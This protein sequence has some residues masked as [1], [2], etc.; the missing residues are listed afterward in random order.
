MTT[1]GI[2]ELRDTLTRTIR[3]V[4]AGDRVEITRDGNAFY[5]L[6]AV[7]LKEN[8]KTIEKWP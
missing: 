8:P 2:K 1:I 7:S 5:H 3:R 4:E 6:D